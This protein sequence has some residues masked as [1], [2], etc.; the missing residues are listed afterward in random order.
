MGRF[1]AHSLLFKVVDHPS[2]NLEDNVHVSLS[3][4]RC[5]GGRGRRPAPGTSE[6][7]H[8]SILVPLA[9]QAPR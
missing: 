6:R 4:P 3:S 7:G 5:R 1:F 8:F 9:S 2:F